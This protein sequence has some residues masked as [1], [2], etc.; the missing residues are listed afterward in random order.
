MTL[1]GSGVGRSGFRKALTLTTSAH[2]KSAK[3]RNFADG[4]KCSHCGNQKHT[5]E[6]CFK[7]HGYPDWWHDLQARKHPQDGTDTSGSS[8]I[9]AVTG[10]EPHLSLI[11]S[12]VMATDTPPNLNSGIFGLALFTS[13]READCSA[14]LLNSGATDHMTFAASNFSS[15]THQHS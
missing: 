12:A 4:K 6:N 14:W 5:L 3:N 1:M 9:A 7:L 11:Q 10:A 15:A 8:G 2:G 13:N